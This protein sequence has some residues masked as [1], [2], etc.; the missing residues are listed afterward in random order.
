MQIEETSKFQK[1]F[2]KITSKV[3]SEIKNEII[4]SITDFLKS[5]FA[6][7]SH[8]KDGKLTNDKI[9]KKYGHVRSFRPHHDYR[10]IYSRNTDNDKI[11]FL[12]IGAR[13]Q[14]YDRDLKRL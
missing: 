6:P 8:L 12:T 14:V 10:I 9:E 2:K 13:K 7:P 5:P 4:Q 11:I 1:K 3:T